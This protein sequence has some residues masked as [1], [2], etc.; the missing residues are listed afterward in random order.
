MDSSVRSFYTNILNFQSHNTLF[1]TPKPVGIR[2]TAFQAVLSNR[3][4]VEHSKPKNRCSATV[5]GVFRII[6]T[7]H[8]NAELNCFPLGFMCYSLRF[9]HCVRIV[10]LILMTPI[11]LLSGLITADSLWQSWM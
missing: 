10:S 1:F 4:L 9:L 8:C 3:Y 2:I 11:V 5:F 7:R 6:P